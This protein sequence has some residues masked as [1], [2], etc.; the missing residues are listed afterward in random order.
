MQAP[1]LDLELLPDDLGVAPM[2]RGV[3]SGVRDG[4][5]DEGVEASLLNGRTLGEGYEVQYLDDAGNRMAIATLIE[6][7]CGGATGDLT[8]FDL[9]VWQRVCIAQQRATR[10]QRPKCDR[11][12]DYE[13]GSKWASL[14][15]T[16]FLPSLYTILSEITNPP[17]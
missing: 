3:C 17:K 13:R 16:N 5:E 9:N 7:E 8:W 10:D 14:S 6:I 4:V 11:E 1:F 2:L 12:H 15:F